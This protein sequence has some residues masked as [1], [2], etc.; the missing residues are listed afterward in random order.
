VYSRISSH[1]L[2]DWN[3][4]GKIMG[5][6]SW[7]NAKKSDTAKWIFDEDKKESINLGNDFY[8]MMNFMNGLFFIFSFIDRLNPY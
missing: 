6:A 4:C 7:S 5:L 3:A 1:I 8:H 2:G